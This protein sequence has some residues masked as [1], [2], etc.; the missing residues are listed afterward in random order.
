MHNCCINLKSIILNIF[1]VICRLSSLSLFIPRSV[2]AVIVIVIIVITS[3]T[4]CQHAV[5]HDVGERIASLP[6]RP[7]ALG[8][9]LHLCVPLLRS[10]TIL[11]LGNISEYRI[12]R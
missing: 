6:P 10:H 8:V 5:D 9:V 12:N 11:G 1:I 3:L 4:A 2:I 7:H